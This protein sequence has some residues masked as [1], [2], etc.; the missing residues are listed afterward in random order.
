MLVIRQ[1]RKA[2][3]FRHT[4]SYLL[5]DRIT[6]R[7]LGT[8][9]VRI[10]NAVYDTCRDLRDCPPAALVGYASMVL[11]SY[12]CGGGSCGASLGLGARA[13]NQALNHCTGSPCIPVPDQAL[14]SLPAP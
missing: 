2:D 12:L 5:L 4:S 10:D 13:V 6:V 11:Q 3:V 8:N 1:L 9:C 14:A 7:W